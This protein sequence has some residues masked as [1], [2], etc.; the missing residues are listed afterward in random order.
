MTETSSTTATT[1]GTPMTADHIRSM[2]DIPSPRGQQTIDQQRWIWRSLLYIT[3][4]KQRDLTLY[5]K[6]MGAVQNRNSPSYWLEWMSS[7]HLD[8][9]CNATKIHEKILADRL[10]GIDGPMKPLSDGHLDACVRF[11][12]TPGVA[13]NLLTFIQRPFIRNN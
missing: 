7:G 8:K 11:L 6:E 1:T 9:N 10:D 5:R 2:I 3:R 12:T 4:E 13:E